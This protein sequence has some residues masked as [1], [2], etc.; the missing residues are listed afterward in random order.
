MY[1]VSSRMT[2]SEEVVLNAL[3]NLKNGK[4]EDAIARF[5]GEFSFKDHGLGLEFNDKD[6]LAEFFRK[7]REF[8]PDSF[9]QT[10]MIFLSGD[11]VI[12]EWTLQAVLT[13]PFY[14]VLTRRVRVS[15]HGTSIVRAENGL[16]TDWADYYDGLTSR[17]TALASYF[18]EWIGL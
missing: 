5:A 13:E 10:D 1:E 17:R 4:T 16:I 18:T 8:Y 3:T 12:T 6:G 14:G 11:H 9:L 7:T 15:L 2:A